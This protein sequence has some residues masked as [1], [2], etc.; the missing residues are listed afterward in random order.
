MPRKKTFMLLASLENVPVSTFLTRARRTAN[1]VALRVDRAGTWR[2][3][4]SA[5]FGSRPSVA[6]YFYEGE[7]RTGNATFATYFVTYFVTYFLTCLIFRAVFQIPENLISLRM[8]CQ[9]ESYENAT[10][11]KLTAEIFWIVIALFH[12]WSETV[13]TLVHI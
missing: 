7:G 13:D 8:P 1:R 2:G 3:K 9:Y 12:K 11:C 6:K 4:Y 10:E 5:E